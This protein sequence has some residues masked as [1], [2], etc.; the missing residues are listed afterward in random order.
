[1]SSNK[2]R[3][4]PS[5]LGLACDVP[6]FFVR[7]S[8]MKYQHISF[9]LYLAGARFGPNFPGYTLVFN[10][11]AEF[12]WLVATPPIGRKRRCWKEE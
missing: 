4:D 9:V 8:E 10:P 2:T 1:L 12:V 5:W 6:S 11:L 3:S 7:L